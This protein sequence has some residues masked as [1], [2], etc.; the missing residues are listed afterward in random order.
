MS[1][2]K[3]FQEEITAAQEEG[4]VEKIQQ[5]EKGATAMGLED[6]AEK[7]REAITHLESQKAESEQVVE[8]KVTEVEG[9]GGTSEELHDRVEPVQEEMKEVLETAEGEIGEVDPGVA[10]KIEESEQIVSPEFLEKARA[11]VDMDTKFRMSNLLSKLNAGAGSSFSYEFDE[12]KKQHSFFKK[13]MFGYSNILDENEAKITSDFLDTALDIVDQANPGAKQE[14]LK[15]LFHR[16]DP[17][18]KNPKAR[19]I[20]IYNNGSRL[21]RKALDI[22]RS[23]LQEN[24]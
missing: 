23:A 5:I 1:F 3:K 12:D 16:I 17:L 6:V 18:A 15:V 20:Y 9:L 4:N 11:L 8:E 24:R 19:M 13:G 10:D 21:M 2:E 14:T 22:A 7:A